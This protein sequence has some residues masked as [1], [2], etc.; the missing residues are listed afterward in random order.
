MVWT[1][2]KKIFLASVVSS[3]GIFLILVAGLGLALLANWGGILDWVVEISLSHSSLS[4]PISQDWYVVNAVKKA[5]PAV[6]SIGLI[7]TVP[8]VEHYYEK[9]KI[10]DLEIVVPQVRE[11]GMEKKEVGSGSGFIV[12]ADG[13][14]VTNKHVV[15]ASEVEYVVYT[16]DGKKHKAKVVALDS[17]YDVAILKIEGS[18]YEPIKLGDSDK[19]E[20]GQTLIAI[21]N[22]LGEF[23]GTVSTGI[24]S[25]LSRSIFATAG[26][27]QME[28]LDE[29]IQTDAAIN[30]GNSGG[31]L[32]N[33]R[34][35]V[36]GVNVATAIG[37]QNIAF[38]L[39]INIVKPIIDSVKKTGKIERPFL[40]I[41]YIILSA[42]SAEERKISFDYGVLVSSREGAEP[43]VKDSPA[44]R[45]GLREGDVI[46]ELDDVKIDKKNTLARLIRDKS[47]GEKIRLKI[48]R[49][50]KESFV[51]LTLGSVPSGIGA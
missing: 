51:S 42:E 15:E 44:D 45:A 9:Q 21:G 19:L 16:N 20:V 50:G 46:L 38:S 36:I 30:L 11:K 41:R 10:G 12:S 5:S 2:N 31:P 25:G 32:L 22:A 23:R 35:E 27:G 29:V 24:V 13:Y 18:N 48:W 43:V 34:G 26:S 14:V 39:P 7:Q 33:L 8:L 40:G 6:V 47:V 17:L 3:L 49:E 1:K 4:S 28:F 37:S